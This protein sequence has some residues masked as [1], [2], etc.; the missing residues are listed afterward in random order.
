VGDPLFFR[1]AGSGDYGK[2]D[3]GIHAGIVDGTI[4]L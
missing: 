3:A 2:I 4:R 1:D